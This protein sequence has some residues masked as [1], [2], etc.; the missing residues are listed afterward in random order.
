MVTSEDR[1]R[2]RRN[3]GQG[4][5]NMQTTMYKIRFNDI[6]YRERSKY[7]MITISGVQPLKFL[8]HYVVHL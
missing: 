3:I 1:E 6:Q 7:F 8:N 4:D 2:G 5:I